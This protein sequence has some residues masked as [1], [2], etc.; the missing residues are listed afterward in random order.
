MRIGALPAVVRESSGVDA[1]RERPAVLWTHN[2]SGDGPRLVAVDTLGALL[3]VVEV[4]GAA[5]FDWEDLATGPCDGGGSC[6]W[7]GDIG[8]NHRNRDTVS[9]YSVPEPR[10]GDRATARAVRFSVRYPDRAWDA[11]AL[12][13]LPGPRLYVVTKGIDH[14]VTVYR[15]PGAPTPDTLVT[16]QEVQRLSAGPVALPD[17][18]TAAVATPDGRWVAVRT[19]TALQLYRVG[20]DGRLTPA[21]D[22]AGV[23]LSPLAEPQGEG[24]GYGGHG[25]FYLTSER[26]LDTVAP[27]SRL[28]CVLP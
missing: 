21:L 8:N 20:G 9:I 25:R 17:Q 28:R 11:E 15:Y 2:D 4:T 5:A 6:L 7:I 14:P 18:V 13:V 10:P 1:G 16:L 3:G 26:G 23:D 24:L 12:F 19:Y 27:L 22:S